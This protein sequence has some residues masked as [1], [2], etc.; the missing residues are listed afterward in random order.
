MAPI[1][2]IASEIEF[3]N[4]LNFLNLKILPAGLSAKQKFYFKQKAA[5]FTLVDGE[6]YFKEGSQK[7]KYIPPFKEDQAREV[8]KYILLCI[9][10]SNLFKYFLV[11]I[12]I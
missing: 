2:T 4:I 9:L 12:C 5:K 10:Y 6:I 8:T 11:E 3:S 7:K 1:V